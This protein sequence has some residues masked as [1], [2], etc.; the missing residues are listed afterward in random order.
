MRITLKIFLL[1]SQEVSLSYLRGFQD[2]VSPLSPLIPYM[3]RGKEDIWSP[4][5][6]TQECSSVKWKSRMLRA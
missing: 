6:P 3:R 2:P 4:C 5:H 1:I